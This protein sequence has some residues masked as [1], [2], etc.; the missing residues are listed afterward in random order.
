MLRFGVA[1]AGRASINHDIT[2]GAKDVTGWSTGFLGHTV[3]DVAALGVRSSL[4]ARWTVL[5]GTFEG[6]TSHFLLRNTV[7]L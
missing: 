4:E 5:G 3:T 6:R 1:L 7:C 2:V